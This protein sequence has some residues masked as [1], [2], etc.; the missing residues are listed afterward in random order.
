MANALADAEEGAPAANAPPAAAAP[1]RDAQGRFASGADRASTISSHEPKTPEPTP[2]PDAAH[3]ARATEPPASWSAAAKADFDRLPEHIRKE[4]LKREADIE[5]GRA[6][7][8]SG[9][10]RLNRLVTFALGALSGALTV[11]GGA[12]LAEKIGAAVNL[13]DPPQT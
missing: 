7:W 1:A 12:K 9:A 13:Q 2:G 6:Q 5:R 8:Q 3:A 4:V 10:E 11:G